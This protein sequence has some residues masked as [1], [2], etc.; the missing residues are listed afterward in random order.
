MNIGQKI[1]II[2]QRIDKARRHN[3]YLLASLDLPEEQ[4]NR[5]HNEKMIEKNK[6]TIKALE[7]ELSRLQ[8]THND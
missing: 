8:E 7:P 4:E 1:S 5:E 3:E 6:I 2:A